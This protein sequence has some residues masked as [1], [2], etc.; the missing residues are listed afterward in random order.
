MG[1]LLSARALSSLPQAGSAPRCLVVTDIGSDIDDHWGL[2]L[3][4]R[5]VERQLAKIEAVVAST[6]DTESRAK[7]SAK[8]LERVGHA[9]PIMVAPATPRSEAYRAA[10]LEAGM[11]WA[12]GYDLD[13]YPGPILEGSAAAAMT[14]QLLRSATADDPL[15]VLSLAPMVDVARLLDDG[16]ARDA[17]AQGRLRVVAMSGSINRG[18]GGRKGADIEFNVSGFANDSTGDAQAVYRAPFKVPMVAAPLDVCGDLIIGGEQYQRLRRAAERGVEP[19]R[20]LLEC[21]AD[22]EAND[23]FNGRF[24]G[25]RADRQS[26]CLYD[27]V[28]VGLLLDDAAARGGEDRS[29]RWFEVAGTAV[30]VTD[31]G[32]TK[33][34]SRGA[35]WPLVGEA[36]QW[37]PGAQEDFAAFLTDALCGDDE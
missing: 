10:G 37:R 11:P 7:V 25:H 9:L 4:L 36:L 8:F 18:Y 21:Y 29:M 27:A 15:V 30:E 34:V 13:S 32:Y 5:A 1:S 20:T 12:E 19:V 2:S 17:A 16:D 33:A 22:W 35:G 31:E 26:T 24:G 28:A 14:R 23:P 3:L 6:Y